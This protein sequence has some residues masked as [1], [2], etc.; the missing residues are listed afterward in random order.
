MLTDLVNP[1]VRMVEIIEVIIAEAH[2]DLIILRLQPKALPDQQH[3]AVMEDPI[4][5]LLVEPEQIKNIVYSV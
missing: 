5:V 4:V 3:L 2:R 1:I